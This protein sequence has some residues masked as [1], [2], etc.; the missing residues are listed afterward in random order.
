MV[1]DFL[2]LPP[3]HCRTPDC[4]FHLRAGKPGLHR[5]DPDRFPVEIPRLRRL[6]CFA[7]QSFVALPDRSFEYSRRPPRP[8]RLRLREPRQ[9]RRPAFVEIELEAL[10]HVL[11]VPKN[12]EPG[13]AA[14]VTARTV[15]TPFSVSS[16]ERW[17]AIPEMPPS[18]PPRLRRSDWLGGLHPE[19]GFEYAIVAALID[20]HYNCINRRRDD[21]H[22][23]TSLDV[24]YDSL[25][26]RRGFLPAGSERMLVRPSQN[27]VS[28]AVAECFERGKSESNR[29]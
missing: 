2:S 5:S 8:V 22:E 15:Q 7:V 27:K 24:A 19:D 11:R 13:R 12:D 9:I 18:G 1:V 29:D 10:R 28:A 17:R 6:E 23:T 26:V 21:A 25:E 4:G 20:V 16:T 3:R 14:N